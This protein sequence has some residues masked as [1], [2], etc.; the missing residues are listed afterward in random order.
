MVHPSSP[1]APMVSEFA[2]DPDMAEL[3]V[4]F[5]REMPERV[6]AIQGAWRGRSLGELRVLAHQLRGSC[7]GY[8]FPAIGLAAGKIEDTLRSGAGGGGPGDLE[9]VSELIGELTA[10]CH[11]ASGTGA[12]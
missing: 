12:S 5:V 1:T 3:V 7:A 9:R 2:D 10:L 8:G 11:R 6:R 4:L